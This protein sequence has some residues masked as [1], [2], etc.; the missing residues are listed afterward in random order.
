MSEKMKSWLMFGAG[1]VAVYLLLSRNADATVAQQKI[2]TIETVKG[3][4]GSL[5]GND[6][7]WNIEDWVTDSGGAYGELIYGPAD[8]FPNQVTAI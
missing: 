7:Q 2:N 5:G 6:V 4:V 1:F 3:D 8:T